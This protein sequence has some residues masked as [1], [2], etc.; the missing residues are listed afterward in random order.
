MLPQFIW[1][2]LDKLHFSHFSGI[3]ARAPASVGSYWFN[4]IF[5]ALNL[6][7]W[8]QLWTKFSHGG[9]LC[10]VWRPKSAG[11][12]SPTCEKYS[13]CV[14]VPWTT[15]SLWDPW[16]KPRGQIFNLVSAVFVFP[17]FH[18]KESHAEIILP[19]LVHSTF[20]LIFNLLSLT[21]PCH[22][23][24]DRRLINVG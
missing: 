13:M 5:E 15:D 24:Y 21:A 6:F 12:L 10:W 19:F 9:R 14:C 4:H 7:K 16:P 23:T 3:R 22:I 20:V 8:M 1:I 11:P 2:Q 18:H 17:M